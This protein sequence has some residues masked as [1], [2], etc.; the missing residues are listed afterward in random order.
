MGIPKKFVDLLWSVKLFC[1][2]YEYIER[3]CMMF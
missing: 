3:L 1:L 2:L